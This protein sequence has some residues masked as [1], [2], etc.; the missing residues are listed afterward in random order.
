MKVKLYRRTCQGKE[1]SVDELDQE[2][3][4][5]IPC[6]GIWRVTAGWPS[7][8]QIPRGSGEVRPPSLRVFLTARTVVPLQYTNIEQHTT[9]ETIYVQNCGSTQS[10]PKCP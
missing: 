6:Y 1:K 8:R 2:A 7:G 10:L 9:P 5:W 3:D 4:V